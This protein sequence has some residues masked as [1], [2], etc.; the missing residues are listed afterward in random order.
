MIWASTSRSITIRTRLWG[1]PFAV[2]ESDVLRIRFENDRGVLD[3]EVAALAEP[4][5]WMKLNAL[6][7]C[8]TG[9]NATHELDGWAWFLRNHLDRI[10]EAL[11]PS[12]GAT[13]IRF[14]SLL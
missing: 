14:R 12:Y 9:E 4:E 5:R 10:A 6:W 1:P 11:G 13:K 8:L 7:Q 3:V 2:I